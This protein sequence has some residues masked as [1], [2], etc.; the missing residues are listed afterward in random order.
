MSDRR[1]SHKINGDR[2]ENSEKG[3]TDSRLK[4]LTLL[5]RFRRRKKEY[6]T[7]GR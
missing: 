6:R 4:V 1:K 2:D 3:K 7:C 5:R